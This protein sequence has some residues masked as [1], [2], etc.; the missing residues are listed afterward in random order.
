MNGAHTL[1]SVRNQNP[2][3]WMSNS[4]SYERGD[5]LWGDAPH[6]IDPTANRPWMIL[7]EDQHPFHGEEYIVAGLTRQGHEQSV[8]IT[9]TDWEIGGAPE[10]TYVSPWYLMTV[11]HID[12]GEYHGRLKESVCAEV[13]TEATRLLS[14]E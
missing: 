7:T 14:S 2:R 8:P 11:K 1:V 4:R 5:V 3:L 6:K 9:P 10:T 12:F 13:T